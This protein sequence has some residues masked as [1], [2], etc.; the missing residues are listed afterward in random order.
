MYSNSSFIYSEHVKRIFVLFEEENMRI[1]DHELYNM[2]I[3]KRKGNE[4]KNKE[5]GKKVLT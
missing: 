5:N 4:E 2:N 3:I 1:M